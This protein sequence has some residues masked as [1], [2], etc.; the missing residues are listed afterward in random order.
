MYGLREMLGK[1]DSVGFERRRVRDIS[2]TTVKVTE[3]RAHGA[4]ARAGQ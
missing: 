1:G 4:G 2:L 3:H